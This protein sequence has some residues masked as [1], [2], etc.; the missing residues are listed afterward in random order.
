MLCEEKFHV[1][2]RHPIYD[3][4]LELELPASMTFLELLRLLYKNGF[5]QNKTAGYGFIINRR[6]CALNKTLQSYVPL[7]T[8][9]V[10]K[11]EINGMLTI[12]T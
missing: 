8:K 4:V 3:T 12:M 10:V 5:I 9:D 2:L 6:L 11:I 7:A 1:R